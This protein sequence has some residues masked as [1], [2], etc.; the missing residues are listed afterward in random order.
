[1]SLFTSQCEGY[2]SLAAVPLAVS[3]LG[4][5]VERLRKRDISLVYRQVLHS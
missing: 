3:S 1:M 4:K 2:L 5:L